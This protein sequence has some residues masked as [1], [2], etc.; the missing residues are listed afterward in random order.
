MEGLRVAQ[1]ASTYIVK[2]LNASGETAFG[3]AYGVVAIRN[4]DLT[5]P[6]D[7]SGDI[8][9]YFARAD[10][11]RLI[12]AWKALDPKADLSDLRGKS[13]SSAR[14]RHCSR[15]LSPPHCPAICRALKPMRRSSNSF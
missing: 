9:V 8:R 11:R 1:G 10:P 6:T 14:P 5:I 15:T 7:A 3:Q 4:G 13:C 12:P 2:S